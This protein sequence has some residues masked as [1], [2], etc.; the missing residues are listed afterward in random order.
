[1][2]LNARIPAAA[3]RART[4][5]CHRPALAR[6]AFVAD[7]STIMPNTMMPTP[8]LQQPNDAELAYMVVKTITTPALIAPRTL[9][10]V[11]ADLVAARNEKAP[12]H[13]GLGP[14]NRIFPLREKCGIFLSFCTALLSVQILVPRFL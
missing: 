13:D 2:T 7:S 14:R 1:M 5:R 6:A 12:A 9:H 8:P 10:E 3:R 11:H 4:P